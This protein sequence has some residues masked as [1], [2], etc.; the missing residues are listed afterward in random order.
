DAAAT[1]PPVLRKSRRE[2]FG[3]G[4]VIGVGSSGRR[5]LGGQ[6]WGRKQLGHNS[7]AHTPVRPLGRPDRKSTRLNSSHQINSYAVFGLKKKGPIEA[8]TEARARAEAGKDKNRYD[9]LAG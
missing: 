2:G 1:V 4:S 7:G 3:L 5:A 9:N 6:A 8:V